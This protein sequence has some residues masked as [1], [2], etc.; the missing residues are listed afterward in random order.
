MLDNEDLTLI[1]LAQHGDEESMLSLIS[2]YAPAIKRAAGR[3]AD[4]FELEDCYSEARCA[5]IERV[6][7]ADPS[8][9]RRFRTMLTKELSDVVMT[10]LNPHGLSRRA[11]ESTSNLPEYVPMNEEVKEM[12]Y[13]PGHDVKLP[14]AIIEAIEAHLT[15]EEKQAVLAY[16]EYPRMTEAQVAEE[17]GMTR[18][19]YQRRLATAFAILKESPYLHLLAGGTL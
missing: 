11:V 13:V 7:N 5:F 9:L 16:T 1:F 10:R 14:E 3:Y 19:T 18:S 12:P 2:K 8:D 15:D 4:Q 17:C 6:L